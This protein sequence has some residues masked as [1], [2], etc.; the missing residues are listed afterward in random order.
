MR[1]F[2]PASSL[3]KFIA[4]WTLVATEEFE[5]QND[6]TNCGVYCCLNAYRFIKG[7]KL[8]EVRSQHDLTKLR[9]WIC[10]TARMSDLK[11]I[12]TSSKQP[13]KFKEIATPF[14]EIQIHN[15]LPR[16]YLVLN[17]GKPGLQTLMKKGILQQ[18][19][20]VGATT[21]R[22]EFS[23][24]EV[25]EG[26]FESRLDSPHEIDIDVLQ[27]CMQEIA[28]ID[29]FDDLKEAEKMGSERMKALI[30]LKKIVFNHLSVKDMIQITATMDKLKI[31]EV[32]VN[33]VWKIKKKWI[34]D[35]HVMKKTCRLAHSIDRILLPELLSRYLSRILKI[36]RGELMQELTS[37]SERQSIYH[38]LLLNLVSFDYLASIAIFNA[39]KLFP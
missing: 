39:Q 12:K 36:K 13:R 29:S 14:A 37:G 9:Y 6:A 35:P 27:E 28:S 11:L 21:Q 19:K 31:T 2:Y 24:S 4:G 15:T 32:M 17:C 22:Y 30:L 34:D 8:A 7:E 5:Q 25:D 33:M 3:K 23:Y 38:P 18:I 16:G 26:N 10:V 1:S 20:E